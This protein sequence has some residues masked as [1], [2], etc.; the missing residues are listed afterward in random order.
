MFD[1]V[2]ISFFPHTRIALRP[3]GAHHWGMLRNSS[4][5]N[6]AIAALLLVTLVGGAAFVLDS[7]RGQNPRSQLAQVTAPKM[8]VT[9]TG[10][11]DE[12][13]KVDGTKCVRGYD[14]IIKLDSEKK[15]ITFA[16]KT[17]EEKDAIKLPDGNQCS[18][19]VKS[20]LP[21]GKIPAQHRQCTDAG[22]KCYVTFCKPK[23]FS[24]EALKQQECIFIN[25]PI[26][27]NGNID[28][29]QAAVDSGF[30][31]DIAK[32]ALSADT[33]E[34][35]AALQF[36]PALSS[37]MQSNLDSA[38]RDVEKQ[39][40][41]VATAQANYEKALEQAQLCT[42]GKIERPIEFYWCDDKG[43][44]DKARAEYQKELAKLK[45]MRESA[46]SLGDG[47]KKVEVSPTGTRE[48]TA[49][50]K[51]ASGECKRD[52][53]TNP[54]YRP[55]PTTITERPPTD[56]S[57]GDRT[58]PNSTGSG[59][60]MG[61]LAKYLPLASQLLNMFKPG[62]SCTLRASPSNITQPGQSV[63]LSWTS[64]NAQQAQLS[65]QGQVGPSGSMQ[66][67]PQQT[68][69]YSMQVVGYSQQ[70]Q[71]SP[72]GQQQQGLYVW[73]PSLNAYVYSQAPMSAQQQG[74]PQYGNCQ[75]QVTV[76]KQ[77]DSS[78]SKPTA[79]ISCQPK[80][81]EVGMQVAISYACQNSVASSGSGFTTHNALS[82]NATT[83]VANPS[84]GSQTQTYGLTCSKE[85][86]TDSAQCTIQVNKS[87]IVLVA[88]P[89]EIRSGET[90]NIGWVTGGMESCVISSPTLS[91]FT[92]ENANNTSVS[93]A[94]KTPTLSQNAQFVLNCVTK[95]GRTKS[96][97]T[98][99][100]II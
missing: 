40:E 41:R 19:S 82:G 31:N 17:G 9:V 8:G 22:W 62:P 94:A 27:V 99:V 70:Q 7:V 90:S 12:T 98:T 26:P 74:S 37:A 44:V 46:Q 100:Q 93:G 38:F 54:A 28:K 24:G 42:E 10:T 71:S 33:K 5:G 32:A 83:T 60:N 13:K 72:Y 21:R 89:K 23:G 79:Q 66:V 34:R 3:S 25:K 69:T 85:G 14:Y 18:G 58:P 43:G 49:C 73:N 51:D 2:D 48:V 88:N 55:P 87:S 1:C 78:E 75:V 11:I 76:G 81:V 15:P 84:I 29:Q 47:E 59:F 77:G 68:T 63:T 56:R 36:K 39:E 92:E 4:R 86:V 96:A 35:E 97:A 50:V 52:E 95:S 65:N 16:T 53:R 91:G 67:Q 30:S 6:T 57:P 61:D 20:A 64:E 45:S 80:V